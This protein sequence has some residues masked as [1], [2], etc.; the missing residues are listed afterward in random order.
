MGISIHYKGKLNNPDLL[1]AFCD[2][3][4]D[5]AK[6]MNWN[7]N[8]FNN[9]LNKPNSSYVDR[10][11]HIKGHIP[12]KGL[13][14]TIHPKA[15]SLSFL[16]DKNGNLRNLLMMTYKNGKESEISNI[17]VKTQ[18]A[19]IEIHITIIKLLEYIKKKYISNLKVIDEGSYWE[20][21]DKNILEEKLSFLRKK[22]DQI[23][24]QISEIKVDG[25]D[26][27]EIILRKIETVLKK[28][29]L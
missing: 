26:S 2:E 14:V 25:T 29:L 21:R 4:K 10:N 17:F 20:T 16:F 28:K 13:N 12:I 7:F 19:P 22:I 6:D 1:N 9:D 11:G 5:I 15:E 24:N 27:P 23:G 3:I 8:T 18:F